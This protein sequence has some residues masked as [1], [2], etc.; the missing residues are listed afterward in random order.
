MKR[1]MPPF[2]QGIHQC[3]KN[4]T[5]TFHPNKELVMYMLFEFID[6]LKVGTW[7]L[8]TIDG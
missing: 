5:Y 2:K 8:S 4:D 7:N 3:S 1:A 6:G